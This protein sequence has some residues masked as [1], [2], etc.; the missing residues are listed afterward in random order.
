MN[1]L[2]KWLKANNGSIVWADGKMYLYE[3]GKLVNVSES[4]LAKE[5]KV[6]VK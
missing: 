1:E 5:K 6:E 4:I 3:N 2:M